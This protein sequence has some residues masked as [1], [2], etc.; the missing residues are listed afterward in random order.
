MARQKFIPTRKSLL[1]RLRN[2]DDSD[3]W[4]TF[5]ETY[6]KLIYS[7]A[8]KAGLTKFEAED[9][10]QETL[11]GISKK[12]PGFRYDAVNG[13]FKGWLLKHTAWRISDQF[14]MRRRHGNG[15]GHS[16]S[17]VEPNEELE[18]VAAADLEAQWDDEWESCLLAAAARRV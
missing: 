18:P 12:M 11:I 6:W 7:T 8:I 5:Y 16:S 1:E 9:A 3:S 15:L 14:R 17:L 10:V 4:R 2:V 13:S